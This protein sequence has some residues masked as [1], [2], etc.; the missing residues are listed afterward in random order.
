MNIKLNDSEINFLKGPRS[1]WLELM[2]TLKTL[3]EFIKGFR[4]FHFI[5]PCITVFGSARLKEDNPFYD[6]ARKLG[7]EIAKLGYTVMTGGG[8]GIMEAANRGAKDVKGSSIGCNIILP[9]EQKQNDYLDKYVNIELFF[10]RK[11]LLRKYSLAFIV[12]PGGF[13]TLDEFFET[14]TL[15]Q[16]RKLK[17]FPLI[18]IGTE[19]YNDIKNQLEKM[20]VWETIS[21][22]DKDLI[23]F[24]DDIDEVINYLN[25]QEHL[26][27][28]KKYRPITFLGEKRMNSN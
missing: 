5:A 23:L 6:K 1:R 26:I 3:K 11:E 28:K 9:M 4:T 2:F 22:D 25:K 24:T 17:K 7:A 14:L 20:L 15:I 13:G 12:F 8:G 18:I 21:Y 10:V 19:Y 27:V 16:T